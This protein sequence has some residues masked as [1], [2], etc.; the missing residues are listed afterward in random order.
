MTGFHE[1][2]NEKR[3]PLEDLK[4]GYLYIIHARNGKV[5]V[6]RHNPGSRHHSDH[7]FDLPRTKFGS[8]FVDQ[9]YDWSS[10]PP[11]GTAIPLKEVG[12]VPEGVDLLSYLRVEQHRLESEHTALTKDEWEAWVHGK[13]ERR[14]SG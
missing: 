11:Y 7:E 8:T 6:Y 2:L 10:G 14:S 1:A 13:A 9:E 5:G 12:P 4:P 3:I